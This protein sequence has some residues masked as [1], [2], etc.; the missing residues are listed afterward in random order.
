[1]AAADWFGGGIYFSSNSGVTWTSTGSPALNWGALAMPADGNQLV[2]TTGP[3]TPTQ[4][5]N[6]GSIWTLQ[7]TPTPSLSLAPSGGNAVLSWTIPS[8]SFALQQN[9]N[10]TT[11]NWTNVATAPVLN[12]TNLQ[13]QVSVSLPTSGILFY[14][15]K[16]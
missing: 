12:L 14:R 6:S 1:L 5:N 15:L 16:H 13:N 7:T 9:S 3:L 4:N 2:A 10:L 8:L 11:T